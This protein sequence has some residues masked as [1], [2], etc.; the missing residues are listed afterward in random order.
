MGRNDGETG[1]RQA[2]EP[3]ADSV[4]GTVDSTMNRKPSGREACVSWPGHDGE[5]CLSTGEEPLS[6][7]DL[8]DTGLGPYALAVDGRFT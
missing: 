3:G 8:P 4:R 6:V 7:R 2:G 5:P 1:T